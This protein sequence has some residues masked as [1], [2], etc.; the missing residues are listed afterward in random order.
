M[1]ETVYEY[2]ILVRGDTQAFFEGTVS[3]IILKW[4]SFSERKCRF[5]LIFITVEFK[6]VTFEAS[7]AKKLVEGS[8]QF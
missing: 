3:L 2:V 8:V 5:H 1:D 4:G 7:G 6:R